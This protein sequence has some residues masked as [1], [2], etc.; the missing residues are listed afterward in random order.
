MTLLVN[1]FRVARDHVLVANDHLKPAVLL[2]VLLGLSGGIPTQAAVGPPRPS[3][4]PSII[5]IP[6]RISLAQLFEVAEQQM[7]LQA[8]NWRSWRKSYGVNTQYRAWRGPLQFRLQG[9]V[10]T[11]QA[12]VRYWI[13]VHKKVLGA[14]D[15]DSSCGVNEPPRQAVIGVQV[16]FNWTPDWLLRP[17]FRILPT[18]FLDRCEMTIADIDVTPLIEKEFQQQL[19]DRMRVAL[20]ELAPRLQTVR[21]QAEQSWSQLQQPVQLHEGQWLLLNPW[22]IALSPLAGYGNRLDAMLALILS[23]EV[24]T[25]ARPVSGRRPLPALSQYYPRASGLNLQLSVELDYADLGRLMTEQLANQSIDI[26]GYHAHVDAISVTG[27][28]RE[29]SINLKLSG[30]AAGHVALKATLAFS[31]ES[32][33]FKLDNLDY[34]YKAEDP[35]IEAEVNFL[36]GVIR[37]LL[38]GAANQ[39]LQLQMSQWND[40]LQALLDNITPADVKLDMTSLQLRHA[41]IDMTA[42]SVNLNGLAVGHVK[43]EFQ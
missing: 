32:Q 16:R 6:L 18:R 33:Q 11:V 27:Q 20:R 29:I 40:R 34:S 42:G 28:G 14:I 41:E 23:P 31:P 17:A 24:I 5:E 1:L 21:Q 39:Q 2:I 26:G 8:G 4:S 35:L 3:Q 12:H 15:L 25:G 19:E 30:P 10:L 43:I 9:E 13:R 37:K 36:G 7:P 38:T 22:G